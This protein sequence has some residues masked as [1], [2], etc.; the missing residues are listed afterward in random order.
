MRIVSRDAVATGLTDVVVFTYATY[1]AIGNLPI[2]ES[3]RGVAAVGL[4]LGLTSRAIVRHTIF[5]RWWAGLASVFVLVAFG[6]SAMATQ[7]ESWLALL[8]ATIMGL[9]IADAYARAG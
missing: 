7:Y 6:I 5:R 3:V 8:M 1:L 4:V 2:I 9:W